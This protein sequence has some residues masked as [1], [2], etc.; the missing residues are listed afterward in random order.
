[1]RCPLAERTEYL[2]RRRQLQL[3]YSA[4]HNRTVGEEKEEEKLLL[5][6]WAKWEALKKSKCLLEPLAHSSP[7]HIAF[8]VMLGVCGGRVSRSHFEA[9]FTCSNAQA[10]NSN[11]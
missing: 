3:Q 2:M 6:G 1:M 7:C 4:V 8:A 11:F 5:F 10:I 9:L